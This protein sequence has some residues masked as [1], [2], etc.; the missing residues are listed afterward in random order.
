MSKYSLAVPR[1]EDTIF[2]ASLRIAREF[3]KNACVLTTG[4]IYDRNQFSKLSV[5]D[6]ASLFGSELAEAVSDGILVSP[7]KMAKLAHTLPRPDAEV[8]DR[9]MTQMG[10]Q[11]IRK[12]AQ[13]LGVPVE[14]Q[15]R[16]AQAYQFLNTLP[17]VEAASAAPPTGMTGSRVV[18]AG[19]NA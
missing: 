11:P 2:A 17:S 3:I 5:S 4:S 19:A 18:N 7:K 10:Q 6:V 8:L 14:N 15:E 16:L 1:P 13:A 9:L 12:E